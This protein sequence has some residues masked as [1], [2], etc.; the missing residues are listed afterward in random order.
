MCQ[1]SNYLIVV[2]P[3]RE[4]LNITWKKVQDGDDCYLYIGDNNDIREYVS[5]HLSSK[6]NDQTVYVSS[7][8][9]IAQKEKNKNSQ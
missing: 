9:L 6:C 8:F 2:K 1:I 5:I 4:N 7:H 3:I